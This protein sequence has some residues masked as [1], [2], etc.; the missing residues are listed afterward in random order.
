MDGQVL[1]LQLHDWR[2]MRKEK[3]D[4]LNSLRDHHSAVFSELKALDT[5][6]EQLPHMPIC[7]WLFGVECVSQL[8]LSFVVTRRIHVILF[9]FFL[10]GIR[11]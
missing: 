4:A 6:V 5:K 2:I 11:S 8:L 3:G 7:V 10:T 1:T 9:L